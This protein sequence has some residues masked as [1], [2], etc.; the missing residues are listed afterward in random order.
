[1]IRLGRYQP[2]V[3]IDDDFHHS[4]TQLLLN[5]DPAE[6]QSQPPRFATLGD[7]E[8]GK[9][10]ILHWNRDMPYVWTKFMAFHGHIQ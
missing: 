6:S 1:M 10:M 5:Q 9:F 8:R 3:S 2:H 7:G 4:A